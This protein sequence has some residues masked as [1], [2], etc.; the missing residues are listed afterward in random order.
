MIAAQEQLSEQKDI[1]MLLKVLEASGLNKEKQ[2]VETLVNYLDEMQIKFQELFTQIDQVQ[3]QLTDLKKPGVI[4]G[5][6]S[7]ASETQGRIVTIRNNLIKGSKNALLSFKED[8]ITAL[9]KVIV[10]M[11]IP[12]ALRHIKSGIQKTE[13]SIKNCTEQIEMLRKEVDAVRV[14]KK[15][16]G[17]VLIGKKPLR[18]NKLKE[19]KGLLGKV[20]KSMNYIAKTLKEMELKT[21]KAIEK[22]DKFQCK[23]SKS[24]VKDNLKQIRK[25]QS[26]KIH[27][28]SAKDRVR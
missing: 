14:H 21:D 12:S 9:K 20:Q 17:R 3:N 27:K 1:S 7:R 10:S 26:S 6:K 19:G 24:S 25:A 13:L 28:L 11:K 15:N 16:I 2:E 23:E 18:R 4:E 8:G 5:L 22:L